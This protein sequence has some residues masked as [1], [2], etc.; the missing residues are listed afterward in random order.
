MSAPAT[1]LGERAL[2][3]RTFKLASFPPV[4]SHHPPPA[5]HTSELNTMLL[6]PSQ[7][8]SSLNVRRSHC[9]IHPF[10]QPAYSE[11]ET[12]ERARTSC[13]AFR[14]TTTYKTRQRPARQGSQARRTQTHLMR[15]QDSHASQRVE[16]PDPNDSTLMAGE[17]GVIFCHESEDG[18]AVFAGA[19]EGC[20]REEVGRGRAPELDR[21]VA[22]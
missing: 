12:T 18:V 7:A 4:N 16:V 3:A 6:W 2:Q 11:D 20:E 14:R 22:G 8:F 10:A 9:L 15:T 13:C 1:S 17:E 19:R 5:L 21:F